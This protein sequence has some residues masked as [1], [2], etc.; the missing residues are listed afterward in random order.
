[1]GDP[2]TASN[3][4]YDR[5]VAA[6]RDRVAAV[7]RDPGVHTAIE[8][9]FRAGHDGACVADYIAARFSYTEPSE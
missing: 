3:R 4:A 6:E 9:L 7:L 1:M 2:F 5:G 8:R